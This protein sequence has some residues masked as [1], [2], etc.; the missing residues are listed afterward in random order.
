[1][2]VK[3]FACKRVCVQTSLCVEEFLCKRVCVFLAAGIIFGMFT[4][5]SRP[6]WR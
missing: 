6:G 3:A 2:C 1:M 4:T 5:D